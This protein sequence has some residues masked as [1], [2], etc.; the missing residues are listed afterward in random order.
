MDMDDDASLIVFYNIV[1]CIEWKVR[2]NVPNGGL[3]CCAK[4][5]SFFYMARINLCF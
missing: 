2:L 5:T 4:I 1:E 3:F